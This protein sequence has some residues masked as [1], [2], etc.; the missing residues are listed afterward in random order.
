MK[1]LSL[2]KKEET[3]VPHAHTGRVPR[4]FN[5][6]TFLSRFYHDRAVGFGVRPSILR[7]RV[8]AANARH[9]MFPTC[10]AG[11]GIKPSPG[12]GEA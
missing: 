8:R 3:P 7:L 1:G 12:R 4:A 2:A 5:R 11:D 9:Y 10:E 6:A